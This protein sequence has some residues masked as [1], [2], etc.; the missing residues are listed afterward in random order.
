MAHGG[1][2]MRCECIDRKKTVTK[3][4]SVMLVMLS[5]ILISSG[6]Y[7]ASLSSAQYADLNGLLDIHLNYFLSSNAIKSNGLPLGAYKLGETG[8]R[9]N[10]SNPAEWGYALQAYVAAAERGRIT[11]ADASSRIATAL[12]TVKLLQDNSAQSYSGGLFYPYYYVANFTTG[13]SQTPVHDPNL[14]IPSMDN[15]LFYMSLAIVDGWAQDNNFTSLSSQAR[16][17]Y[18]KMNFSPFVYTE[19]ATGKKYMSLNIYAPSGAKAG[20][21]DIYSNEGGLTTMV[22]YLSGS[23]DMQTYKDLTS[24]QYRV[25]ATSPY[26]SGITVQ[27]ADFFNPM[28]TWGVRPLAGIPVVGSPYSTNSMVNTYKCHLAYGEYLGLAYPGFSDAMTQGWNGGDPWNN[29]FPPNIFNNIQTNL[30][31]STPHAFF[32]P[33]NVLSDLDQATL[34]K[35]FAKIAAMKVDS[36]NYYYGT[37]SA[38]PFGFLVATSSKA[39]DLTFNGI[40]TNG[41]QGKNIFETLSEAYVALSAYNA[42]Q[43]Q[44]KGKEFSYFLMKAPN[45]AVNYKAVVAYLYPA[46]SI[47]CYLNTDCG[48]DQNVGAPTCSGNSVVQTVRAYTCANPGASTA[49]CSAT[50]TNIV[51]TACAS[52]Q[53]CSNATCVTPSC[54]TNAQCGTDAYFGTASCSGLNVVQPFRT[55]TCANPGTANAACTSA[56][57]NKTKSTCLSPQVCS[58][59]TCVTP[60]CSTNAQCGTNGYVGTKS[61]SGQNVT[62]AYRTFTCNA[63]GTA[64]ATCSSADANQ[65][66]SACVSPQVC[67][68]G[69][70]VTPA[71]STNAQCGTN[72]Y[73]GA[74]FCSGNSISKTFRTFVCNNAG[75]I[76]ASCSS[77]D[78]NLVQST[79]ASPTTCSAGQCTSSCVTPAANMQIT[80]ST[81]LCSGNYS[82]A[83][84]VTIAANNVTLDCAG[85]Q[86]GYVTVYD[87]NNVTIKNCRIAGGNYIVDIRRSQYVSVLDSNLSG[88]WD[89]GF[90]AEK[91]KGVTLANSRVEN[92]QYRSAVALTSTTDS[93]I[94]N[95]VLRNNGTVQNPWGYAGGIY[96]SDSNR[97]TIAY[98]KI[99]ENYRPFWSASSKDNYVAYNEMCFNKYEDYC[100][101]SFVTQNTATGNKITSKEGAS[102]TWLKNQSTACSQSCSDSDNI[103]G[104]GLVD[105]NKGTVTFWN[106]LVTTQFTD[107]CYAADSNYLWEYFC[108]N[109]LNRAQLLTCQYGCLNGACRYPTCWSAANCGTDG[110][111]G[112]AMC[113]GTTVVQSYRTYSC[114]SPGT[115]SASCSYTDTNKVK[116]TCA[117][118][119]VCSN[120][121]CVTPVCSTNAQCGTNGY[122]GSKSCS[123]KNV[124]QAYRTY[125]CSNPATANAKCNYS[126]ANK[127]ISTCTSTQVCA[128]GTCTATSIWYVTPKYAGK[129]FKSITCNVLSPTTCPPEMGWEGHTVLYSFKAP[130]TMSTTVN[131]GFN[132]IYKNYRGTKNVLLKISAGKSSTALVVVNPSLEINRLGAF[133]VPISSSLFT[134]GVTNYIQIYGTNITPVGYGTNPPNFK[135]NSIS[136]KNN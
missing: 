112:N 28:F 98:N 4:F 48:A 1:I 72:G 124:I 75:T 26:C 47:A 81:V 105:S 41:G 18:S 127:T 16:G 40:S 60:V 8:A 71:C 119:Q 133:T 12:N 9:Y 97:N 82:G 22:A 44:D 42:L 94:S 34:D 123:G 3:F 20:R 121:T 19:A 65:T 49:K 74:V 86:I 91:S 113:S 85:A 76:S 57:A 103:T 43:Q 134:P 27:E 39:N 106:G 84:N 95:N 83:T 6:A 36:A 2:G 21:C 132:V 87:R 53:V 128:S 38:Y 77:A 29:Y 62:Q 11:K 126:D 61:C 100:G 102:C 5:L 69:A 50:D 117:T 101:G 109:D 79:C 88:S 110:Y 70:C 108:Q 125:T 135:I 93:N 51:K 136:L 25:S 31:Y 58:N 80:A 68:S 13:A 54:T 104:N 73:V 111:T 78:A 52:A 130:A 37:G 122:V 7:S 14:Y 55:F 46:Y 66:Q 96:L 15:A 35:T 120:A 24:A 67:S 59:A 32:I 10:Y 129:Y 90:Y 116:T 30:P 33:L 17:I 56:D 45:M 23:I 118:G 63:P 64:F 107:Q 115:I 92:C 131:L 114:A 99:T 89:W